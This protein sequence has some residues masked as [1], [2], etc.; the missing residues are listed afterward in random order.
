M[1]RARWYLLLSICFSAILC[2]NPYALEYAL[3]GRKIHNLQST[4]YDLVVGQELVYNFGLSNGDGDLGESNAT[5]TNLFS[6]EHAY[7]D[8]WTDYL[9]GESAIILFQGAPMREPLNDWKHAK[10][11]GYF[12]GENYP[13]IYNFPLGWLYV[14]ES[15]KDGVW[16]WHGEKTGA[17]KLGWVWTD[18]ENYP[19]FYVP[20]IAEWTFFEKGNNF[21]QFYDF[22]EKMW[23][24][25][26]VPYQVTFDTNLNGGGTV[27]G[28]G[29]F[30][31]WHKTQ[32]TVLPNPAFTFAGWSGEFYNFPKSFELEVLKNQ[33]I[34]TNFVP[35]VSKGTPVAE[36]MNYAVD[37][38]HA[39]EGLSEVQKEQS[40][41]EL[42][43]YGSS[44]TAG[45]SVVEK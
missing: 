44:E 34:Y 18:S 36:V 30:Y 4:S 43:K 38:I 13:W 45:F 39:M 37:V 19:Y 5:K 11:F 21:A 24:N 1:N 9:S 31:H 8:L 29:Q 33:S 16:I 41:A 32:I 12:R 27:A 2:G 40:I 10:W 23:F 22:D 14:H 15:V 42:L 20:S 7:L 25:A 17:D 35:L 28:I 3:T 6:S 26:N